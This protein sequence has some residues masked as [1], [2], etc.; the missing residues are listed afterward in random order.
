MII[1]F[2]DVEYVSIYIDDLF[3]ASRT[4]EEHIEHLSTVLRRLGDNNLW[5]SAGK[6]HL[7][8]TKIRVLGHIISANIIEVDPRKFPQLDS[9]QLPNKTGKT[10]ESFLGFCNYFRNHIPSFARIAFP[11]ESVRKLRRFE[12]CEA[13][14]FYTIK[15]VVGTTLCP[16]SNQPSRSIQYP[17]TYLDHFQPHPEVTTTVSF[18]STT[19]PPSLFSGRFL[20]SRLSRSHANSGPFT[21]PSA[22]QGLFDQNW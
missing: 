17:S 2:H 9:F 11:L 1:I 4:L 12:Q 15:R 16:Q 3:I 6:C 19:A 13:C 5:T 10:V 14:Q 21:R 8:Y 22:F 20:T 7:G 18:V